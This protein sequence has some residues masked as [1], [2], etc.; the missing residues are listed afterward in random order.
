MTGYMKIMAG[1]FVVPVLAFLVMA[2]SI[3][4]CL[5]GPETVKTNS[6]VKTTTGKAKDTAKDAVAEGKEAIRQGVDKADEAVT[7]VVHHIRVGVHKATNVAT[8]VAAK[9]KV[10]VTN[11]VDEVTEA[12]KHATR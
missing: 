6:P 12:I 9:V 1:R 5:G 2:A 3:A 4:S 7:N 10:A 11:A 8:N